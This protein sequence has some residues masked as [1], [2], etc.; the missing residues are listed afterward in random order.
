MHC[1]HDCTLNSEGTPNYLNTETRVVTTCNNCHKVL[2]ISIYDYVTKDNDVT[3]TREIEDPIYG[4]LYT[5]EGRRS[6][7]QF[8][9]K[10]LGIEVPRCWKST[11][12]FYDKLIEELQEE[13]HGEEQLDKLNTKHKE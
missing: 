6:L 3:V 13:H 2:Y 10:L 4:L 7:T 12:P 5:H 9:T 1:I 11:E 8:A